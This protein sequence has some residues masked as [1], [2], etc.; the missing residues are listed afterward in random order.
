MSIL[1]WVFEYLA[2]FAEAYI[3]SIFCGIFLRDNKVKKSTRII[4]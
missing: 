3:G 4:C 1:F 2:T